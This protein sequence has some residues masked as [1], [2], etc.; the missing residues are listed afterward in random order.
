[1]LALPRRNHGYLLHQL[2]RRFS[3][4]LM[5]SSRMSRARY[6]RHP[7]F[8]LSDTMQVQACENAN[9]AF[10]VH[11]V[12]RHR[13]DA[14]MTCKH[15]E[16]VT[17]RAESIVKAAS[18][19]SIF[20]SAPP[21]RIEEGTA[22]ECSR[23]RLRLTSRGAHETAHGVVGRFFR[24]DSTLVC[25][26]RRTR[27][28][29]LQ[30]YAK[31]DDGRPEPLRSPQAPKPAAQL[32][33]NGAGVVHTPAGAAEN[34][35]NK[36]PLLRRNISYALS[37]QQSVHA[38]VNFAGEA[39][40]AELRTAKYAHT[41]YCRF[42]GGAFS[43]HNFK[44]L[45]L[46]SDADTTSVFPF[47]P[48]LHFNAAPYL[49]YFTLIG[50]QYLGCYKPPN[51]SQLLPSQYDGGHGGV[52][53]RRRH[54]HSFCYQENITN[55]EAPATATLITSAR[56][57]AR[58]LAVRAGYQ[59]SN[60]KQEILSNVTGSLLAHTEHEYR[61]WSQ[62]TKVK[63]E[64]KDKDRASSS[65]KN[66]WKHCSSRGGATVAERLACSPPTNAIRVHSPVGSLRILACG[67]RAGR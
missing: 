30:A 35:S 52:A 26:D 44:Q 41:S 7:R 66:A 11:M 61:S 47:S 45:I 4:G 34:I 9:I 17:R 59:E 27:A 51:L 40:R 14:K 63:P 50:S 67:N 1:M 19:S 15:S 24:R 28:S 2:L 49:P 55:Q 10:P 58:G 18:C 46:S 60:T 13:P 37:F 23:Y 36:L 33:S 38:R 25:V 3:V 29:Q 54:K 42:R 31:S 21:A 6:E 16:I 48:P 12:I 22:N 57:L 5:F 56:S 39:W 20:N 43:A 32:H 65:K 64:M 62:D 53:A 8:R